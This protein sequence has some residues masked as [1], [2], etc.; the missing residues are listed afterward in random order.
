MEISS[1]DKNFIIETEINREGLCFIDVLDSRFSLHGVW[2]D[3]ERFVRLP[4]EVGERVN[5]G[6]NALR[7]HT[8]GGRVRFV[9]DSPYVAIKVYVPAP[10][11][12]MHMAY[13]GQAGIDIYKRVNG[14]EEYCA[15][16]I[17]NYKAE[18]IISYEKI[19]ELGKGEKELTL[20][21]P[22]YQ[23]VSRIFVGIADTATLRPAPAYRVDRPIVY[24][25]SSITQGGCA[26]RPGM[27]Y[28]GVLSRMLDADYINLG[29][30]GSARGEAAMAEYIGGLD[31]SAFVLD[32]DHNAPNVA[33]LENTHRAFYDIVRA[34]QKE[35][36][37]VLVTRPGPSSD[38]LD[39]F[40]VIRATYD[41][42][43]ANGDEN[44]YFIDG[45]ELMQLCGNEGTVDG[46][47][48]TDLGFFSMAQTMYPVLKKILENY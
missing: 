24:Y 2:H 41:Y 36:P 48:P 15:S 28:Q 18:K 4:S 39:R 10:A 16:V 42:G 40:N 22:L 29:F 33:H 11:I 5:P 30:S 20:N 7:A 12:M 26:S 38:R 35:T 44:L 27:S 21:M 45:Y 34:K 31:M 23:C 25:G 6:V 8:A 1:I 3:G 46:C 32:Y 9:T 13:T 47:H 43:R 37:I 17:P 14:K 19:I